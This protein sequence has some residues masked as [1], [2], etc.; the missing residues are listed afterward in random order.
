MCLQLIR[1]SH[2]HHTQDGPGQLLAK[3]GMCSS[4]CRAV[5]HDAPCSCTA[6]PLFFCRAVL[7]AC[8]PGWMPS[9]HWATW[10]LLPGKPPAPPTTPSF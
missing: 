10:Q 2:C 8:L 4:V 1:F 7:Q 9:L 3:I 5:L 6:N